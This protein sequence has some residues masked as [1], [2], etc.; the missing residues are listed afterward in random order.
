MTTPFNMQPPTD[1][2]Y[3]FVAI[4]GLVISAFS[5]YVPQLRYMEFNRLS[6]KVDAIYRPMLEPLMALDDEARIELSCAIHQAYVRDKQ[7]P[8][9]SDRCPMV[10]EIKAKAALAKVEVERLR[11][12]A[13]PIEVD[14]RSL[15]QEYVLFLYV[16]V[17]G[18]FVGIAM[19]IGGFWLWYIRLQKYLD[20]TLKNQAS[21]PSS[22]R[23]RVSRSRRD[24]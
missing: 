2:L 17:G 8:P 22:S 1:N 12:Q 11:A 15:W 10:A 5:V 19:G 6:Q 18:L 16:G 13:I 3:K 9:K 4:F 21:P 23:R 14:R 20:A 7:Q 24:A